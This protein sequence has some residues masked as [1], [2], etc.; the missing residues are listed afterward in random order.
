MMFTRGDVTVEQFKRM[1]TNLAE[2]ERHD[3]AIAIRLLHEHEYGQQEPNLHT[4]TRQ[5]LG[6]PHD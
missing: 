2:R 5:F 4:R 6:V 3:L 1:K